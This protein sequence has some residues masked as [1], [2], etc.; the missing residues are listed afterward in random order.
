MSFPTSDFFSHL[1]GTLIDTPMFEG[2]SF[3]SFPGIEGAVQQLKFSMT[4]MVLKSGQS[5]LLLYNGQQPY[6]RRGD[7]ISL[8]VNGGRVEFRFNM[9]SG[10]GIVRSARNISVGLWH[11]VA[12]E[13]KLDEG[14]LILDSDPPVKATSPCCSVGLNLVLDLFIGGV[15]NFTEFDTG[16]VGVS[17]G[18]YGCISSVSVDGREINLLKSNLDLRGI[19]QCTECLLPCEIKPCLNNATCIPVGKTG[20]LCSCAPGYT[21]QKCEFKLVGSGLN[22]TCFNGGEEFPSSDRICACPLGYGGE[23]CES[24]KCLQLFL[25]FFSSVVIKTVSG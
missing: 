3:M 16:K 21:G 15:E 6:P 10:A 20:F 11:T 2:D 9:G 18:L 14:S 17:S 23:R 5:M 12:V 13:R 25:Q 8:A 19:Q 1:P 7:F 24:R 4:F 22:K